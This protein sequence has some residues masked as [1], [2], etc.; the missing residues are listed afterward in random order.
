MTICLKTCLRSH[1]A[2]AAIALALSTVNPDYHH[3]SLLDLSISYPH[4]TDPKVGLG[5]FVFLTVAVPSVVI[6]YTDLYLGPQRHKEPGHSASSASRNWRHK[7]WELNASLLG[8]GVSLTTAT[9]VFTGVKNLAGKPRPDFLARYVPD[10]GQVA[11]HAVGGYGQAISPLWV[12]VDGGICQ[13][14]DKQFLN[15]GYRSFPSGYATGQ[16]AK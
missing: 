8:L 16:S 3:F 2:A 11:A 5:L 13:Q 15:D 12:M 14:A 9:I 10:V 7:L 6:V 1:S 4:R